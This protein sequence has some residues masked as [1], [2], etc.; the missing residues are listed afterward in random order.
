M[1][2]GYLNSTDV[3]GNLPF[4]ET[5]PGDLH[6][7]QLLQV[8]YLYHAYQRTKEDTG[9]LSHIIQEYRS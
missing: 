2:P 3:K 8:L 7:G 6:D 9:F 1:H 5:R 4:V